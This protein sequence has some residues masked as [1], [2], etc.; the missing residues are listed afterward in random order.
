MGGQIIGGCFKVASNVEGGVTT[1]SLTTKWPAI[2]R[3]DYY[4]WASNYY[5]YM[6]SQDF[7]LQNLFKFISTNNNSLLDVKQSHKEV[8]CRAKFGAVPI[9]ALQRLHLDGHT[10][11]AQLT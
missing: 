4:T 8:F 10:S 2:K 6:S 7:Q 3:Y 1:W 11:R 9:E 5:V